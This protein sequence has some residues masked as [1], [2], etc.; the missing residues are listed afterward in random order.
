M[1]FPFA[2]LIYCEKLFVWSNKSI[3]SKFMDG[4]SCRI[5]CIVS[6]NCQKRM[7]ISRCDGDYKEWLPKE[8]C[9]PVL[10]CG[11]AN[12]GHG[13]ADIGNI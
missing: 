7:W 3:H 12:K 2:Q 5:L 11:K 6:S 8:E 13:S 10:D 9:R 1:T 4:L